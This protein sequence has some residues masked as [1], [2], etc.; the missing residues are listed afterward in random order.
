M[1]VCE[2]SQIKILH[3]MPNGKHIFI[4]YSNIHLVGKVKDGVIIELNDGKQYV[5]K[6]NNKIKEAITITGFNPQFILDV[7]Y[8][9][10]RGE[11]RT[12]F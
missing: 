11:W 1:I 8:D 10:V 9:F 3:A 7:F 5:F 4:K 12:A 2:P 6:F